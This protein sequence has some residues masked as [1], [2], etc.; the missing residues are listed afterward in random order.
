MWLALLILPPVVRADG[1][2]YLVLAAPFQCELAFTPND[3]VSPSDESC[4]KN[5]GYMA[6]GLGIWALATI[7]WT[8]YARRLQT[9]G[10]RSRCGKRTWAVYCLFGVWSCFCPGGDSERER[11]L[12]VDMDR[13]W[14]NTPRNPQHPQN[15]IHTTAPV[16]VTNP[17]DMVYIQKMNEELTAES[18]ADTAE[19]HV[20]VDGIA[21]DG[22]AVDGIAV[23]GIVVDEIAVGLSAKHEHSL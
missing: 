15:T 14:N 21:V 11:P 17:L 13:R 18:P 10:R 6:T 3:L 22:I 4:M 23:D 20:V 9:L 5:M 16:L 12:R 7:L 2:A 8:A 19:A 1:L